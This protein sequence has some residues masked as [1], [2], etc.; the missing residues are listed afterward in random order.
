MNS[1][2]SQ[3]IVIV[4][5]ECDDCTPPHSFLHVQKNFDREKIELGIA[6][7]CCWQVAVQTHLV[8]CFQRQ[9]LV[10]SDSV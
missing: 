8:L 2:Q 4:D 1:A 5:A 7:S 6:R 9:T 3:P 10:S